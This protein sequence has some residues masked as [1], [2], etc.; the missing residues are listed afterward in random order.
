MSS[1]DYHDIDGSV[2]DNRTSAKP[3]ISV[4]LNGPVEGVEGTGFAGHGL[5]DV[6]GA[7]S[8]DDGVTWKNTNLS[9]SAEESSIDLERKDI[10]LYKKAG[11]YK[12]TDKKQK[13]F[14][15]PGDVTNTF[16]AVAGNKV[17]VAWQ[18][19]FCSSGQPNYSLD[20]DD[21]SDAQAARRAAIATYLGDIDLDRP[22]AR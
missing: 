11:L 8:L 12:K 20:N 18:S 14:P 17:L 13:T 10:K 2:V 6:Y 15:Y 16:H 4:Y 9:L 22:L 1:L 7:V 19:R 21:P 3:L 5:R